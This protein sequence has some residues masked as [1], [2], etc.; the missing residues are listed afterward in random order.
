MII[1]NKLDKA[2]GPVGTAAGIVLIVA[3]LITIFTSFQSAFYGGNTQPT[4][5]EV[6]GVAHARRVHRLP[7]RLLG[8]PHRERRVGDDLPRG[9]QSP[10]D[11]R[12]GFD[13][14][15]HEVHRPRLGRV[16][17]PARQHQLCRS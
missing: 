12:I 15:E 14:I 2:F 11:E 5:L 9:D 10:L 17:D 6:K 1:K 4:V 16:E 3:G 7:H 13:H 8:H